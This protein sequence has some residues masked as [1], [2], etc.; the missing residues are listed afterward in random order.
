MLEIAHGSWGQRLDASCRLCFLGRETPK[1]GTQ[2]QQLSPPFQE[3]LEQTCGK[4]E[5]AMGG[6]FSMVVCMEMNCC[7]GN[8]ISSALNH[9]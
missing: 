2:D 8:G 4:A 3:L 5:D 7:Y 6:A 1:F 9:L